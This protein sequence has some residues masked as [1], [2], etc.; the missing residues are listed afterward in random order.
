[1]A[2]LVPSS[3]LEAYPA[4]PADP[5]ATIPCRNASNFW[6]QTF[7]FNNGLPVAG[8]TLYPSQLNAD[9][10]TSSEQAYKNVPFY[11]TNRGYGVFVN[12]PG[13]VSFE[14]GSEIVSRVQFSVAGQ[15]LEYLVIYGLTPAEILGKYTGLTGRPALPP[16]WSFGLWLST[17]FTT[18]YDEET[19]SSFVDG[20]TTRDLPLSVFHFDCFWM[21]EFQ[22]CDFT[23][24]DRTFP[25]PAGMLSR[26]KDKG[27]RICVWINPYIAQRSQLFAYSTVPRPFAIHRLPDAVSAWSIRSP[28]VIRTS[29]PCRA[30]STA[31]R[32]T[33]ELLA[34][35]WSKSVPATVE[36]GATIFSVNTE[37]PVFESNNSPAPSPLSAEGAT[38]VTCLP[39][40]LAS[41]TINPL[42]IARRTH[43]F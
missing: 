39:S 18:S 10:G 42:G 15:N 22:W 17:S 34:G 7:Q 41:R 37:R 43:P 32:T 6:A 40:R 5:A 36:T 23:W 35:S 27:L 21:R 26:L 25:D 33:A 24:D 28:P 4:N 11:L 30:T 20:M 12:H 13:P 9:A 2:G 8:R 31:A 19:V 3:C 38:S 1:V 14:V 29:T 16:P